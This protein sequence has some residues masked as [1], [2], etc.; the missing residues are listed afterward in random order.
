MYVQLIKFMY[1]VTYHHEESLFLV[2]V[3]QPDWFNSPVGFDA[4]AGKEFSHNGAYAEEVHLVRSNSR[5]LL[6]ILKA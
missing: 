2:V 5:V 1:S 6:R 4:P 3:K